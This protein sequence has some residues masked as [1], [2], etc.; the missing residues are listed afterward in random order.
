MSLHQCHPSDQWKAGCHLTIPC[1]TPL[2]PPTSLNSWLQQPYHHPLR[3]PYPNFLLLASHLFSASHTFNIPKWSPCQMWTTTSTISTLT[4]SLS[5]TSATSLSTYPIHPGQIL[6]ICTTVPGLQTFPLAHLGSTNLPA[7][8]RPSL[9]TFPN[10]GCRGRI[11]SRWGI[12]PCGHFCVH[13]PS[14]G[15]LYT[16]R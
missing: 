3:M 9:F 1:L 12:V 7:S 10:P 13:I 6:S 14:L 4:P 8:P 11:M 5:C 16:Q 15:S 2:Q